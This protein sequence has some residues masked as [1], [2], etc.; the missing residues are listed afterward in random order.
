MWLTGETTRARSVG[1]GALMAMATPVRALTALLR[2]ICGSVRHT[3][4]KA[5]QDVLRLS[6]RDVLA[7]QIREAKRKHRP[8]RHLHRQ[9]YSV[10]H[11]ILRRGGDGR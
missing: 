9:A 11:D 5:R 7:A 4:A 8:V 6:Q 10:T 1:L 2:R 3:E